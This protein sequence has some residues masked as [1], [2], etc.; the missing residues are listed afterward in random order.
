MSHYWGSHCTQ[1]KSTYTLT[2]EQI[3][4]AITIQTRGT[5]DICIALL[6]SCHMYIDKFIVDW[7]TVAIIFLYPPVMS[8]SD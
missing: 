6:S 7:E 5:I 4:P 1:D 3:E 2:P 8:P